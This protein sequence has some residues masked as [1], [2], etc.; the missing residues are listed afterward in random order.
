MRQCAISTLLG[1]PLVTAVITG[2][3]RSRRVQLLFDSGSILTQIHKDTVT[4][5]G[6]PLADKAPDLSIKGVTGPAQPGYSVELSRL[7]V[8]GSRLPNVAIGAFDFGDWVQDGIDG[9]LL[10]PA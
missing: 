8:L 6:I 5:I 4:A 2:P 7:F 3:R 10:S 1:L 9:L